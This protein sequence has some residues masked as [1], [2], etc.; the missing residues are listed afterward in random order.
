MAQTIHLQ[1]SYLNKIM[2]RFIM[3]LS[4]FSFFF[5]SCSNNN[6]TVAK[7][8]TTNS[9]TVYHY[10]A[11][12]AIEKEHYYNAIT[13]L[14]NQLLVNSGFNGG[15]V[16][17]KNGEIVFEDYR[18]IANYK[19]KEPITATSKFHIASVSKTFTAM[20]VLQLMEQG[21]IDLDAD[22]RT[23]L[24]TF[25]YASVTIKNLLSHRSGLP[26]YVHL[27][28]GKTT[29][30]SKKKGK[31][32]RWIVQKIIKKDTSVKDGLINNDDVLNFLIQKHP[33]IEALPNTKFHY[34]NTNFA[35]LALVVEKVTGIDFPTYMKQNIFDP[36]GMK[37]T[38]IF[39][40]KD[41]ANYTPSYKYNF[42]PYN[43]EKLDCVYGDKNVYSTARDLLLWDKALYSNKIVTK[44]TLQ[45][46]YTPYSNEKSGTHN[47]GLGW[48]LFTFPNCTI[49]FH[50]G[51]W[52]GNNAVFTRLINDTATI[53]V[54]GNK[55]NSNIYKAK[56]F[57]SVFV[58]NNSDTLQLEEEIFVK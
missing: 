56:N 1:P 31:R 8:A 15:I 6:T 32:G 52:H 41:T 2:L 53:I 20:I 24:K 44:Q 9:D 42:V 39:S 54:L 23:Y 40:L 11:L 7:N 4:L 38:Y 12:S 16:I 3:L 33:P 13:P 57:A 19:T 25:P 34:C 55:F 29:E 22:V 48:R 21:K 45:L 51:W 35:L 27:I 36:L 10:N 37:D 47:Y 30:I 14:Y 43:L 26:N 50:N 28:N 17:A 46:A 58:K 18:G 49:P 5:L